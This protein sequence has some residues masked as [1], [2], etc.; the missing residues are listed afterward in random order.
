MVSPRSLSEQTRRVSVTGASRDPGIVRRTQ[1]VDIA[2]AIPSGLELP[3][4]T[5]VLLTIAIKQFGASGLAKGCVASAA[6]I[7]LLFSPFVT[8]LTR[9]FGRS[10]MKTASAIVALGMIGFGSA[11]LGNLWLMVIGSIVGVASL[12]AI[13]PLTTLTYDRNFPVATRGKRVAWGMALRVGVSAISGLVMGSFLKAH[14]DRWAV[15][16]GVGA[17]AA[18][19]QVVLL[20]LIPSAPL[21]HVSGVRN[22]PWPHFELLK[23]DRQLRLTITAWM[24]M[25]FGNLMLLPLRVEYLAQ[26]KY[27]IRAD[28]DKIVLLTVVVPAI[29]RLLCIPMF[30]WIFDRLSFFASRI[31]VNLLFAVYVGAFFTGRSDVGLYLG[32]VAL[33]VGG[34]GGDLMWTLWVTKFSPPDRVADYMGL[35]TFFTGIRGVLAPLLAFA[36]IA[37]LPI[38][39]VAIISALLM[40][41]ASL[42]LVPEARAERRRR[43]GLIR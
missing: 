42:V 29:V 8:S 36:V 34:A 17:V 35:H 13:V 2:R 26:P 31:L 9:R 28:A 30:G 25:G 43:Q 27:G 6:E 38:S 5:S 19:L 3:L 10:I 7:G 15:V 37:H 41:A 20:R 12:S 24:L 23:T 18:A 40:V 14:L 39:V 16:V 1:I 32:A 22:R 4:E 11:T 21:E 33:G